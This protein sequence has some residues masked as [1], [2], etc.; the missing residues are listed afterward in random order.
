MFGKPSVLESPSLVAKDLANV[1]DQEF[2]ASSAAKWPPRSCLTRHWTL[3]P[4]RAR[5]VIRRHGR[6]ST[7]GYIHHGNSLLNFTRARWAG[8]N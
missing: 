7:D 8:S 6:G 4:R 1:A 2:G 3:S 5:S